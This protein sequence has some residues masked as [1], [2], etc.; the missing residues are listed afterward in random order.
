MV[1]VGRSKKISL[2]FYYLIH[3]VNPDSTS[4]VGAKIKGERRHI[5]VAWSGLIRPLRHM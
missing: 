4:A 3:R 1:S 5:L 2:V